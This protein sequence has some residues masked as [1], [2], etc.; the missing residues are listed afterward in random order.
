[1]SVIDYFDKEWYYINR[2]AVVKAVYTFQNY[3]SVIL[4]DIVTNFQ[5]S[6]ITDVLYFP[7]VSNIFD[8]GIQNISG[9]GS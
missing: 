2:K 9:N 1:M 4:Y 8:L 6:R 5:F 7:R 3:I